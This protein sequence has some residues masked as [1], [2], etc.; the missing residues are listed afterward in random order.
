MPGTT[1]GI[2]VRGIHLFLF[3]MELGNSHPICKV[4]SP[5]KRE[6]IMSL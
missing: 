3:L 4:G 2:G 1:A 5:K 6:P